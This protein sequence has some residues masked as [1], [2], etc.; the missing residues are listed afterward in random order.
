MR[1]SYYTARWIFFTWLIWGPVIINSQ[2]GTEF[3]LFGIDWKAN[4]LDNTMFWLGII[5][6]FIGAAAEGYEKR[7]EKKKEKYKYGSTER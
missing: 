7:E 3:I 5:C 2:P 6:S 1:H 4:N